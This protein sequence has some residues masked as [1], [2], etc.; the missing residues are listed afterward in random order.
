MKSA[1]IKILSLFQDKL[2]VG[3][4][5]DKYESLQLLIVS[6][7]GHTLSTIKTDNDGALLDATWTPQ[8]N[9]VYT[10]WSKKVI[11]VTESGNIIIKHTHFIAPLCLSVSDDDIPIIYLAG[12][13]K[14]VYQSTDNGWSWSLAFNSTE[15]MN[16]GIWQAIKV[17]NNHGGDFW[18][19]GWDDESINRLR[20]YNVGDVFGNTVIRNINATTK[21]GKRI[22]VEYSKLAHDGN[23]NIFVSESS[24]FIHLFA[25]TGDYRRQLLWHEHL[26][27]A[28]FGLAID[29]YRQLL[30][31]GQSDG[32]VEV[33]KLIYDD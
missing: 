21:S 19:V 22:F 31:V 4:G 24:K 33:F 25:V 11:V 26:Q 13:E 23:M 7:E 14:G 27:S 10:T 30:Y 28:P 8:G 2:L 5:D 29:K 15:G 6:S 17:N 9:I 32:L 16:A 18:T 12:R 3:C 1:D 20:I